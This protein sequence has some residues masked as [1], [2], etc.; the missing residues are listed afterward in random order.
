[1]TVEISVDGCDDSTI[2]DMEL[3]EVEFEFIKKLSTKCNKTSV[4]HCMPRF[5]FKVK[6]ENK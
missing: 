5:N 1:M 3:N 6:G 2:F 4:C